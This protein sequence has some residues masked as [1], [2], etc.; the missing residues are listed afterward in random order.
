MIEG[1]SL[2]VPANGPPVVTVGLHRA[3]V[4]S[5]SSR[6]LTFAVPAEAEGGTTAVTVGDDGPPLYL[7]IA[8]TLA[9]GLHQVDSPALDGLGRLY[10]TQSGTRG[11]KVPVPLYRVGADGAREPI[12]VEIANPTSVTLGPDGAMFI[13]SRF[14]GVVHRLTA[15][16][17]VEAYATDLGVATGLAF[18]SDG[19][20]FVGDRA[21]SIFRVF[22]DRHVE[23]FATIPASVAAFHLAVGPDGCL[24]VT[25]PTLSSHDALYR[26]TPDRLVD[27]VCDTFGRPQGL[28]FDALGHLYV[29]DALAGSAGLYRVDLAQDPVVPEL[30]VSAASL[31]GV[32]L[33]PSGGIILASSD[34]IWSLD[35]DVR[36]P[37]T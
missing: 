26:I 13:S 37:A 22:P 8:R 32:C 27:V 34:T 11:N 24:Y 5:A 3:R 18:A 30:V 25:A 35:V 12:A 9:T 23:V 16:D 7:E 19:S 10:V 21:G 14:D 29:V 20:L 15:D 31:V 4:S 28:A 2:P 1:A 6:S 36:A 33:R 17:Q